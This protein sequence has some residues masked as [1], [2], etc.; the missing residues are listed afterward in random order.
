MADRVALLKLE[1]Q[2]INKV[3]ELNNKLKSLKKGTDEYNSTLKQLSNTEAQLSKTRSKLIKSTDDL[4]GNNKKGLTGVSQAAGASTSATLELGRVLSDMPYGIRGVANNL[5]QLA[6][7]LFFMSKATDTATGKSVG[8][9][10]A[11]KNLLGGL[12]GPAGILIAFQGIIALFDYF[13][14]RVEK[15]EKSTRD[16]RES[17]GGAAVALKSLKIV[18]DNNM[19]SKKELVDVVGK[20]NKKY[21]DLNIELDEEGKLTKESIKQI[22]N[23]ILA[24]E[25]LAK[26]NAMMSVIEEKHTEI[27]RAQLKLQEDTSER[28]KNIGAKDLEDFKQNKDELVKVQEG[29]YK[30]AI[31]S[32]K[33]ATK[34]RIQGSIDTFNKEKSKIESEIKEL[35]KLSTDSGFFDDFFNGKDKTQGDKKDRP[36]ADIL[37]DLYG[38]DTSD[39]ARQEYLD[40][41]TEMFDFSDIDFNKQFEERLKLLDLSEQLGLITSEQYEQYRKDLDK[42]FSQH[43]VITGIAPE[44]NLELSEK[45]KENLKAYRK[46][47]FARMALKSDLEDLASDIDKYK[48]V[49]SGI[50]DFV[51]AQFE[52]ELT[53][54]QNK[55]TALNEQLNQR[56]LNEKLSA[57]ERKNIQNQIAI[58]DEALRKKQNKIKKK[59]FN[60]NKALQISLAVANT[61][62]AILKA[63]SSQL[64]PFDP[65]SPVRAAAAAKIA[66]AVGAL[67]IATIASSKF[68][69]DSASTPIRTTSGGGSEG[70]GVGDRS[71]NFNLVGNTLGNQITDAIQ[72]QFD[73]PLKAYVV[74]RDITSQQALDAN[75]KGTASF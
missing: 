18:V 17:V 55:T 43:H 19:L 10:G 26:A 51:D 4:I 7:N 37:Q 41:L 45:T 38:I 13:S 54:E 39:K 12:I 60:T 66:G 8:F 35:L 27:I 28:L 52:R 64:T 14:N 32:D 34:A 48:Q 67:Q 16:F 9:L 6:S 70:G 24:L 46:E 49:L 33:L 11:I 71:F 22:N 56:L 47:V 40:N 42:E 30:G 69:P 44:L 29:Y 31:D 72:G 50:G 3:D 23:K 68:Q 2:G 20:V 75:I 65:S 62:G 53:I 58:N 21:K 5:Q 1:I 25:D 73:Q 15:A 57:D 59:Q 36:E 74:S 63:Y 61:A